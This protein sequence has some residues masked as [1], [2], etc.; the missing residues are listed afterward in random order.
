MNSDY[1][2]QGAGTKFLFHSWS[3]A[4]EAQYYLLFPFL[5]VWFNKLKTYNASIILL[6]ISASL[7]LFFATNFKSD[8]WQYYNPFVR[9]WE[10]ALG[11]LVYESVQRARADRTSNHTALIFVLAILAIL[12]FSTDFKL[13]V[14]STCLFTDS[15][16]YYANHSM[17]R[18]RLTSPLSMIGRA[19]YSIYLWHIPIFAG[20][21]YLDINTLYQSVFCAVFSVFV[22]L[23][24]W[25]W[26]ENNQT[27]KSRPFLSLFIMTLI[28]LLS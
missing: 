6:I 28:F 13:S 21:Q 26:I 27:F 8:H 5:F 2:I 4:V 3:L 7:F 23:V 15:I 10:I 19:S 20:A 22:G 1:W 17:P 9:F 16:L 12:T 14:L 18:T 24:S 11:W 25:R